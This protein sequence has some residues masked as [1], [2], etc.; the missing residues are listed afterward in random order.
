MI[1]VRII[2]NSNWVG[3]PKLGPIHYWGR[4][5]T[6]HHNETRYKLDFK[7][8]TFKRG[9][10]I[11]MLVL[12][13]PYF[14]SDQ[15]QF[16]PPPDLGKTIM[17]IIS[18]RDYLSPTSLRACGRRR[19]FW[20]PHRPLPRSPPSSPSPLQFF[21]FSWKFALLIMCQIVPLFTISLLSD[22]R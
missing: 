18:K 1:M 3:I 6:A 13:I 4:Y 2:M 10:L 7:S 14:K 22:Q 19:R 15:I 12:A 17:T 5:D 20:P 9:M 21:I 16:A 11:V 8:T